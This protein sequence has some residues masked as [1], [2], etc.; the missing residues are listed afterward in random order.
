MYMYMGD[1]L[2][3]CS[4]KRNKYRDPY[5][6]LN[7]NYIGTHIFQFEHKPYIYIYVYQYVCMYSHVYVH[8]LL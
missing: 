1:G 6:D 8:I 3:Y 4:Q 2:Y 5:Y 7:H